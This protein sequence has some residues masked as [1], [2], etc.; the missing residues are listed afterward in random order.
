MNA[1]QENQASQD[2]ADV[3]IIGAG[4]VGLTL[5]NTLGMAGV[6]VIVAEKLPQIIDY[7]RAIGIDDESLRTLQA[8]GLSDQV[9]AHITPHHWMRF[10]TA[11]GQCFACPDRRRG[12]GNPG[13]AGTDRGNRPGDHCR[14]DRPV[15]AG[16][17]CKGLLHRTSGGG[18]A[19]AWPIPR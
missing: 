14:S 4:P 15:P 18:T 1:P 13:M 6:R 17:G 5:A 10:Y 8:A 12:K 2:D 9:Q 11:S 19:E 7:P 3:L 16:C